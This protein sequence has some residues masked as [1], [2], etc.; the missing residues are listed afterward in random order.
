MEVY[1]WFPKLHKLVIF[2]C[3]IQRILLIERLVH[4]NHIHILSSCII[5]YKQLE[6]Q[7]FQFFRKYQY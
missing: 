4:I 1:I 2:I 3:Y 7:L 6:F 5:I